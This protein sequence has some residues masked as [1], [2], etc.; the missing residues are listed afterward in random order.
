MIFAAAES[1]SGSQ[2][3]TY[4]LIGGGLLLLILLAALLLKKKKPAPPPETPAESGTGKAAADT[5]KADA[6]GTEEESSR[7][8]ES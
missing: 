3:T 6:P 5:D 2:L 8:K 7:V 4:A 1:E